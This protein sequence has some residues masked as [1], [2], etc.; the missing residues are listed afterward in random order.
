MYGRRSSQSVCVFFFVYQEWF[1]DQKNRSSGNSLSSVRLALRV[2][3]PLGEGKA[4]NSAGQLL[5]GMFA[6]AGLLVHDDDVVFVEP[7][8][9]LGDQMVFRFAVVTTFGHRT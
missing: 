4:R 2:A 8:R 5:L 9:T 3:A 6:I 7:V 1:F